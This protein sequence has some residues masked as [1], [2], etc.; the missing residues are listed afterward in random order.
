MSK[1]MSDPIPE[2]Y[3]YGREGVGQILHGGGG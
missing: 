1:I 2:S 3:K